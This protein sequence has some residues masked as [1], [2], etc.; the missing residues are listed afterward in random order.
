MSTRLLGLCFSIAVSPAGFPAEPLTLNQAIQI[1][2]DRNR[3]VKNS[4]LDAAIANDK[5]AAARTHQFPSINF[6]A[7]GSQQLRSIAFTFERGA[8]GT[9]PNIG[10]VPAKDTRISTPL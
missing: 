1:A 10:D 5:L 8:L 7:L 3:T 4:L 6:F 9:F 2:L